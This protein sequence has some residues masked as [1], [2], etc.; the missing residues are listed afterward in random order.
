MVE[1]PLYCYKNDVPYLFDALYL[2]SLMKREMMEHG[3]GHHASTPSTINLVES[4]NWKIF[5]LLP[6]CVF[7]THTSYDI[8]T[9]NVNDTNQ[10]I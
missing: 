8:K 10:P 2:C 5:V 4:I 3:G 1:E 7:I 6:Q 9:N